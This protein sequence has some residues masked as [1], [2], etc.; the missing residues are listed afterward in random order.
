M[1]LATHL[2]L[3][4]LAVGALAPDAGSTTI[5]VDVNGQGDYS[6]LFN[7]IY[8]AYQTGS[9]TVLVYPGTYSGPQNRD[10]TLPA[11]DF[12]LVSRDGPELTTLNLEGSPG[13]TIDQSQT[14]AMVID[15]FT[16]TSGD[17]GVS[18]YG[19]F[20][21]D[22][23]GCTIRNCLFGDSADIEVLG[24]GTRLVENCTFTE[25]QRGI[26]IED[27]EQVT[28]LDCVFRGNETGILLWSL[29]SCPHEVSI[30]GCDFDSNTR[31]LYLKS[32]GSVLVDDC[33]FSNGTHGPNS[34]STGT[35]I[36]LTT[37]TG[38]DVQ[39]RRSNFTDNHSRR[40]AGVM[41][42]FACN[43]SILVD[44]CVFT[45]NSAEEAGGAIWNRGYY[46]SMDGSV[47]VQDCVFTGNSA[48]EAGG[49]ICNGGRNLAVSGCSFLGN[50]GEAGGAIYTGE[51]RHTGTTSIVDCVFA[52][53][54]AEEGGAIAAMFEMTT[55]SN[56]EFTGNSAD[57]GA[58]IFGREKLIE[59]TDCL[60]SDNRAHIWGGG[61]CFL[62]IQQLPGAKLY[63]STFDGNRS[64]RGAA[65]MLDH[66]RV[67][68]QE[69]TL[70]GNSSEDASVTSTRASRADVDRCILSFAGAGV[71]MAVQ[72]M[73]EAHI[74]NCVSFGNA[75]GDSLT[76]Y[77]IYGNDILYA[78]PLLCGIAAGDFT[79]CANSPCLPANNQW[80]EAI[81]AHNEG[82][83]PCSSPVESVTWGAIKAL[84]R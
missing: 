28:V 43:G 52:D 60:F 33:S 24:A 61:A 71:P 32:C 4:L 8:Y 5:T 46:F 80:S 74:A 70:F 56:C 64:H 72:L 48:E 49:A 73:S 38:A 77:M 42:F 1:K 22:D 54:E 19:V 75:G 65:I 45:G 44:D 9:D 53:N 63:N 20:A 14:T 35:S 67:T 47:S 17:N 15:G 59:I 84:Y 68:I 7:G 41:S 30:V 51:E 62:D 6:T 81:G 27:P 69:C 40:S 50:A 29:S 57:M 21:G 12:V 10:L 26:D 18:A 36:E 25:N 79:L 55:I 78:D 39:I 37:Q 2:L 83:P 58:A 76:G 34:W 82:C 23:A 16:F 66:S 3:C 13:I 11:M 31:S